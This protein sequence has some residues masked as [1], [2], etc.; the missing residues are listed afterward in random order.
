MIINS[1]HATLQHNI[2]FYGPYF[3]ATLYVL[4]DLSGPSSHLLPLSSGKLLFCFNFFEVNIVWI[5]Y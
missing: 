1:S 2:K 3:T 5:P 4:L